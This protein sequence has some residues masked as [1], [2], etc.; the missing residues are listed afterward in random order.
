VPKKLIIYNPKD[1]QIEQISTPAPKGDIPKEMIPPGMSAIRTAQDVSGDTHIVRRGRLQSKPKRDKDAQEIARAWGH[2][3]TQRMARLIREV[4]A[5]NAVRW[6]AMTESERQAWH[7][8]RQ[9][10]LD[11]PANTVDPRNVT[12]P[13]KPE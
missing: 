3:R 6:D 5:I 2:L 7:E 1:G 8:Y 9:A 4:D 12:W 11:L 10:L 13:E